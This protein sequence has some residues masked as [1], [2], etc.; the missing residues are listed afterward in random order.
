MTAVAPSQRPLVD[1]ALGKIP[2]FNRVQTLGY[3]VLATQC[4]VGVVSAIYVAITQA[5]YFGKSFH[6]TWNN[7]NSIWHFK[8]V[9]LIGNWLYAH[10]DIIRHVYLRDAPESIVAYAFVVMLVAPVAGPGVVTLFDH[11][12]KIFHLPAR[13]LYKAP[14]L[15]KVLIKLHMPSPWQEHEGRPAQTTVGQMLFLPVS[16]LAAAIPGEVVSSVI[17]FGSMALASRYGYHSPWFTPVSPWVP[18][19][20]GLSGGKFAGHK[21]AVKVGQDTQRYFLGRRLDLSYTADQWLEYFKT[22]IATRDEAR[23][24]IT[25][26]R[27]SEPNLLYPWSYRARFKALREKHAPAVR[28][29]KVRAMAMSVGLFLLVAATLYGLYVRKWGVTHGYWVW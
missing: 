21:P 5:T 9:P 13:N 23:D 3:A 4:A 20:I 8:A 29:S 16:M 25:G 26:L 18:I 6:E 14:F 19:V 11:L 27:H 22:G 2:F 12:R 17:I 1:Q 15:D 24:H 7:L 10:W 28:G